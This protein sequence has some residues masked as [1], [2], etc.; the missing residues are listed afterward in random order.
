MAS[1]AYRRWV[2]AT[3]EAY[4]QRI[5]A[6]AADTTVDQL[7]GRI[8]S[9]IAEN[10]SIHERECINLNPATNVMNPRAESVLASGIGTRPSLGYPGDKYEMGL[11]AIEQIEV[12]A[13]ELV[14]EVF[15]SRF[16]EIRVGSGA[17]ANLYAFMAC[18]EPGDVIIV[19]SADIGGHVTHHRAGP[20]GLYGL[21]VHTAPVDQRRYTVDIDGLRAMAVHQR[22]KLI[23]IG[24]SLNLCHHPVSQIREIADAVGARVLFDA[25]HLSGLI[26]GGQW[27]NPLNEGA[28]LMTMSTYK[29]LGG[30]PSGLLVTNDAEIAE[31]VDAIAYPGMTANF[32]VAKT[33]A[34]AISLLDW[35][36]HGEAYG[37]ELCRTAVALADALTGVGV[38]IYPGTG[39]PTVSHQLAIDA[40]T[41]GGGQ[42]AAHR[43]RRANILTSGIGLPVEAPIDDVAGLRL[44]TNEIVRWGMT[45]EH[46]PELAALVGDALSADDPGALAAD[47]STFRQRF[48]SVHFIR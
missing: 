21:D 33:A 22:P 18:T 13:A 37:D 39:P 34:L 26:A 12:I 25:A 40:R 17:M 44:G 20:A 9:L 5:A 29:S 32:D 30:P 24:G 27:P 1:L 19:P 6:E 28:H 46:M 11:E 31:R 10:R 48:D 47:V 7:D 8:S 43:L 16:A 41:L 36:V 15:Q 14:A 4:V 3:C 38:P 23:S 42:T 35:K 2:P 45:V